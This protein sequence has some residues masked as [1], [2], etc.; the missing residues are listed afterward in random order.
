M[1]PS[2]VVVGGGLSGL[3][4][5]IRL[6]RFIPDIV[7]LEQ[8]NRLG[9]LNSYYFRNKTLFETGLHAITNYAEP[10]DKRAPLNR[11][12]RQLKLS[13]KDLVF[14]EQKTSEVIFTNRQSLLFANDFTV[15][16]G[17]IREKFPGAYPQFRRLLTF[18]DEFDPFAP[19]PF[20]STTKFL[21]ESLG[22]ALL[23]DM[24]LC[25]LMFYGSAV[26]EDMDLS[27]FA[28]MFRAIFLE[29]LFRPKGTIRDFLNILKNHFTALGGTIRLGAKV[30]RF[31]RMGDRVTHIELETGE[32]IEPDCILSTIGADETRQLA[33]SPAPVIS[34]GKRLGFIESIF[35]LPTQ[36]IQ[37]LPV[38][39]TV[40]F[41]NSPLL[42]PFRDPN[43]VADTSSGVI[44]FP[45][46]F[47]GLTPGETIEYRTTHLASY[48]SWKA[49][50]QD[51]TRYLAGKEAIR[52]RSLSTA[53]KIVGKL[54][55]NI[56]YEDT[57]TPLTIERYT[58]KKYGAIY[59]SPDKRK[60]GD[61]G[62]ENMF[63]AGTDQGF[64]G[65]VGSMLSGVSIVNQHLLP[66]L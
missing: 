12:L 49:L 7:L 10:G 35:Q 15:L 58:A 30:S 54:S 1:K 32:I 43:A 16:D 65:I 38:D 52:R 60:N 42:F 66:R 47:K 9:G 36:E 23:A 18:L 22:D 11:L 34:S 13:R 17:E 55:S 26:E 19:A 56:V 24:L 61:I 40:I 21:A 63:L 5:A 3:A 59:G 29:G 50:S 41:Y 46:N 20:R 64:L 2:C 28:I 8:H 57:F 51:P 45:F 33:G 4:A 6:A 62:Y 27:Q 39:K 25:P 44:C 53:E 37:H 31:V 14:L 48:S